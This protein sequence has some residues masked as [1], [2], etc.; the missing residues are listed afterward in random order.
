MIKPSDTSS[1]LNFGH[2]TAAI[3][4]E[5]AAVGIG[6][7]AKG[8]V[9]VYNIS[10]EPAQELSVLISP[11]GTDSDSFGYAVA[12]NQKYGILVGDTGGMF[13]SEFSDLPQLKG[14]HTSKVTRNAGTVRNASTKRNED[15][16]A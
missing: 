14:R 4:G 15:C 6:K 7:T 13:R 3:D 16:H 10:T 5:I 2:W 9:Y 11:D 12:V 8:K 1:N